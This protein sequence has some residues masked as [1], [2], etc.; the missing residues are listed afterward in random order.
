MD[1]GVSLI[2]T[3]SGLVMGKYLH[4]KSTL[5]FRKILPMTWPLLTFGLVRGI[6]GQRNIGADEYGRNWSFFL[7]LSFLPYTLLLWNFLPSPHF[8]PLSCAA[9][10]TGTQN[11]F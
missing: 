1:I 5:S 8:V 11:Q 7:N 10:M 9:I 4:G 6:L 2:I 3:A